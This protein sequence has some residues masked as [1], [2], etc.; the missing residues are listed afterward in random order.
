MES[1]EQLRGVIR[2]GEVPKQPAEVFTRAQR[3][4]QRRRAA[5][6]KQGLSHGRGTKHSADSSAR[7]RYVNE[8][9]ECLKKRR[10][11]NKHNANILDAMKIWKGGVLL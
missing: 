5:N 9:V 10:H 4:S 1:P 2:L 6:A 8:R 11:Y 3:H 7:G